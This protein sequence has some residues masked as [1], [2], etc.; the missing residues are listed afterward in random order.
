MTAKKRTILLAGFMAA[1]L[2]MT[3]PGPARATGIRLSGDFTYAGDDSYDVFS[4][5]DERRGLNASFSYTLFYLGCA[6]LLD[7]EA[8]Y[9]H[10]PAEEDSLFSSYETSILTHGV[11]AGLRLHLRFER[12]WIEWLQPFVRIDGGWMWAKAEVAQGGGGPKMADWGNNGFLY[13]GGGVQITIPVSFVKEKMHMCVSRRFSFGLSVE[14]GYFRPG[15]IGFS[16]GPDE[17][18]DP[19]VDPIPVEGVSL[20]S[21]DLAGLMVNFGLVVTF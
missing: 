9:T 16:L 10:F 4:S 20:G 11:Y 12:K 8:G 14:V 21:L 2:L 17:D 19:D 6:V 5:Q 7:L 18:E 15:P 13:V 3:A 1:A